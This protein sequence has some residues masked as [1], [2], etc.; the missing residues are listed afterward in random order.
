MPLKTSEMLK[1][2]SLN[3]ILWNFARN[4]Q[5][6]SVLMKIRQTCWTVYVKIFL[7]VSPEYTGPTHHP[8]RKNEIV[9]AFRLH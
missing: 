3:M 4:C 7:H 5:T 1:R 8:T 6:I 2:S 9:T